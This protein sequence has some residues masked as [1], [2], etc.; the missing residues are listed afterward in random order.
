MTFNKK[1]EEILL[2]YRSNAIEGRKKLIDWKQP[3]RESS[4]AIKTLFLETIGDDTDQIIWNKDKE[5][6]RAEL[7][8]KIGDYP[9]ATNVVDTDWN[10]DDQ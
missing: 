2:R 7:R 6:W 10:N 5:K 9:T 8:Q 3:H 1:L 4:K